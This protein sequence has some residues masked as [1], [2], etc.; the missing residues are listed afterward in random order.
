MACGAG[1]AIE[2]RPLAEVRI[3]VLAWRLST[4]TART[5]LVATDRAAIAG[6]VRKLH[7]AIESLKRG[8]KGRQGFA[9]TRERCL[10]VL[11]EIAPLL[12]DEELA[13]ELWETADD[14]TKVRV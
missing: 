3:D 6:K 4:E 10:S 1:G 9:A 13:L 8:G 7:G 11:R 12:G 14:A 5:E 2:A